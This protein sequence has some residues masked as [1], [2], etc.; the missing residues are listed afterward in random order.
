MDLI[1]TYEHRVSVTVDKAEHVF[2]PGV[3]KAESKVADLLLKMSG[4]LRADSDEG[5]KWLAENPSVTGPTDGEGRQI[6][7]RAAAAGYGVAAQHATALENR[8]AV[9]DDLAPGGPAAGVRTAAGNRPLDPSLQTTETEADVAAAGGPDLS[10]EPDHGPVGPSGAQTITTSDVPTAAPPAPAVPTP[11]ESPK[12]DEFDELTGE[13]L[14]KAAADANIEGRS[15]M[16]ADD[17]RAALRAQK[18]SGSP[19]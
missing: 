16:S 9:G 2:M 15:A 5:E 8:T 13:A 11:D 17:K 6:A 14:D 4:V 1:N 12:G 18:A 7:A 3:L 10:G 19:S